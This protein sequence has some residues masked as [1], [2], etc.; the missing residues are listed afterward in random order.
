MTY[1][2]YIS[3]NFSESQE[4]GAQTW[5]ICCKNLGSNLAKMANIGQFAAKP[6]TVRQGDGRRRSEWVR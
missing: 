1:K 5:I 3:L 2:N 4:E 6:L